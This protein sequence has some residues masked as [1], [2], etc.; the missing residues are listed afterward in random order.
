MYTIS[1]L[2]SRQVDKPVGSLI[3]T[4]WSAPHALTPSQNLLSNKSRNFDKQHFAEVLRVE[5]IADFTASSVSI[6]SIPPCGKQLYERLKPLRNRL[7]SGRNATCGRC[8]KSSRC[9]GS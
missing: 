2:L 7:H 6:V 9:R 5:S 3:P 8:A 4:N 1:P